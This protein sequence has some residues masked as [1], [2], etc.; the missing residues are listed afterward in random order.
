MAVKRRQNLSKNITP[1]AGYAS[2]V[3][4]AVFAGLYSL[5]MIH[6]SMN[7]TSGRCFF[8]FFRL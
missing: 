7:L 4:C 2:G 5:N 1:E 8:T 3:L 6:L